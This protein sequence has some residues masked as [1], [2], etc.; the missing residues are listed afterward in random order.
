MSF[1]SPV[2]ARQN[3][4]LCG[5]LRAVVTQEDNVMQENESTFTEQKAGVT[6]LVNSTCTYVLVCHA[7]IMSLET[8]RAHT[9]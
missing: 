2:T 5:S 9:Y 8:L 6:Y 1:G 7:R 4:F 3:S